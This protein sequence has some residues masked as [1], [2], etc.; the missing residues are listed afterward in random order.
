MPGEFAASRAVAGA[1]VS[2]T[3]LRIACLLHSL[4][5]DIQQWS[6]KQS[7]TFADT[8]SRL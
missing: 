6:D 7:G 3:C 5:K 1:L 4:L 8:L 2:L